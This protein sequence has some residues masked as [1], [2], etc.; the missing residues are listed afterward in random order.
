MTFPTHW[1]RITVS[2]TYLD[3]QGNPLSGTVRFDG[4]PVVEIAIDGVIVTP[5]AIVATLD[6]TG[7]FLVPIPSTDDPDISPT[8]W[9]WRVTE[10][11]P[12]KGPVYYINVPYN[13]G[14]INLASAVRVA[15]AAPY[16][17]DAAQ[18]R[19]DLAAPTGSTLVGYLQTGTGMV[20]R[21]AASKMSDFI[22]SYDA[23][24]V[25]SGA[26]DA[27]QALTYCIAQAQA[28]GAGAAAGAVLDILPGTYALSK[29]LILPTGVT[30]RGAGRNATILTLATNANC[31]VI[32]TLNFLTLSAGTYNGGGL[33][34]WLASDGVQVAFG[35]EHLSVD[36]NASN[37]SG[38]GGCGIA[39]YGKNYYIND[40]MVRNCKKANFYTECGKVVSDT[41]YIETSQSHIINL[42]A[43]AGVASGIVNYG[44]HDAVWD[45]IT[46]IRNA[47]GGT[48][49]NMECHTTATADGN[50]VIG[51]IH[52]FGNLGQGGFYSDAVIKSGG[53]LIF[54]DPATFAAANNDL[55]KIKIAV[56]TIAGDQLTLSGANTVVTSVSGVLHA[57]VSGVQNG[58]RIT[59]DGTQIG[60]TNIQGNN[61]GGIGVIVDANNVVIGGGNLTSFFS[62]GT[63]RALQIS[64]TAAN[65]G[66]DINVNVIDSDYNVLIS[67]VPVASKIQ[68]RSM[69]GAAH[70]I[71]P[72]SNGGSSAPVFDLSSCTVDFIGTNNSG[73]VNFRMGNAGWP[74]VTADRGDTNSVNPTVDGTFQNDAYYATNLTVGRTFTLPAASSQNTGVERGIIRA[75]AGAF[76]VTV[77][78]LGITVAAGKYFRCK[79]NGSVWIETSAG[80][81]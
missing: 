69:S 18:L 52:T 78:P 81:L 35:L 27:W 44:P 47:S 15:P 25:S 80:T 65:S 14:P 66:L 6:A 33:N 46:P 56:G 70:H 59:G 13:G 68:I 26:V 72:A 49:Y 76:N 38:A 73:V 32:Q 3:N 8:G 19:A 11:V 77:Q 20:A 63:G 24:M 16:V 45:M 75:D 60:S 34:K 79:S 9:A 31:D 48:G 4:S 71:D 1:T 62:G 39:I 61:L 10:C 58:I 67:H 36:G 37:Q 29:P 12:H 53:E 28:R 22:S 21:T 57:P 23:G 55:N 5:T 50:C 43:Y 74:G 2:G 30:I 54:E 7:S 51:N 64:P 17:I 41:S 42:W 40:V